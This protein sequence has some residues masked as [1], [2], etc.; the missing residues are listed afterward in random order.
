MNYEQLRTF[1]LVAEKRSFSAVA[2]VLYLSQPTITSQ[3]KSLEKHLNTTLFERTTK[4]VTL[5]PSAKIFYQYAKDIIHLFETAQNEILRISKKIHGQ[6][7]I[8]CSL[9]IGENILPQILGKFK[10]NYPLIQLT[11]D[12]SN[13]RQIASKIKD[14]VL[15]I[16]LIEAPIYNQELILEP[17]MEDEL[18][19]IANPEFFDP[20]K[21]QI[22]LNELK[23]LPMILR[24]EGSGTRTVMAEYMSKAGLNPKELNIILELGSTEAIKST[25]N[26]GL[27][28]SIISKNAIKKEIQLGLLKPYNIK[29][30]KISR[31]FYIIFHRETV[32]KPKDKAFLKLINSCTI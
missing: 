18:V 13:S 6:L 25:V 20:T 11:V 9:T 24:E 19:V 23:C 28:I 31:H 21:T 5:T 16:G 32:M 4:R 2:K 1:I 17:F 30:L 12:I 7:N 27:G 26:S 22:T 15:D 3:I 14:H 10:E 8:A 29:N